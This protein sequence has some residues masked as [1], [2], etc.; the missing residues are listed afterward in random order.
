[1]IGGLALATLA[2]LFVVPVAY[3]ALRGRGESAPAAAGHEA[4]ELAA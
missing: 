4:R 1:V 3:A 2:T